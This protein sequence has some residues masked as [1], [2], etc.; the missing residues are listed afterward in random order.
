M[1]VAR[2]VLIGIPLNSCRFLFF[3]VKYKLNLFCS[4]YMNLGCK[5]TLIYPF[6]AVPRNVVF[7]L[8]IFRKNPNTIKGLLPQAFL[9]SILSVQTTSVKQECIP[10]GCVPSAAVAISGR[11]GVCPGSE[12]LLGRGVCLGGVC[13]CGVCLGGGVVCPGGVCLGGAAQEGVCL[14]GVHLPPVMDRQTPVKTYIFFPQLLLRT[15]NIR[16]RRRLSLP[17]FIHRKRDGPVVNRDQHGRL[18]N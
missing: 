13:P 8:F 1:S 3:N 17:S 11:G 10:T 7:T 18:G 5:L 14:G 12:C 15:V 2:A 16:E 9:S 4:R 6:T